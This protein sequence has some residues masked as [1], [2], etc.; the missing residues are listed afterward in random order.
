MAIILDQD[1][2]GI[3]LAAARVNARLSQ[4]EFAKACN[5]SESTVINWEKGKTFPSVKKLTLIEQVTGMSL[6]YIDFG[7]Y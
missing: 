5:V 6:N 1:F 3:S 4:K 7:R 2:P